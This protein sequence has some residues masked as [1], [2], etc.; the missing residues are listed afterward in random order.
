MLACGCSNVSL[1]WMLGHV[2][3]AAALE[4]AQMGVGRDGFLDTPRQVLCGGP[5]AAPRDA[6]T[7]S[8][9]SGERGAGQG[10]HQC[11]TMWFAVCVGWVRRVCFYLN[12]VD[13]N[14]PAGMLSG[15]CCA[16]RHWAVDNV[17]SW[18]RAV[19]PSPPV[20]VATETAMPCRWIQ[21]LA[22]SWGERRLCRLELWWRTADSEKLGVR[23]RIPV[24]CHAWSGCFL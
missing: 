15:Q 16:P 10:S 14:V 4:H 3:A 19:L 11:A 7:S 21:F 9:V 13:R 1:P 23:V 6:S 17:S 8:G 12:V 20:R 18:H 2:A 22:P 24:N 5:A